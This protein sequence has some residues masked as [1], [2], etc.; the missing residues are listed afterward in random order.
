MTEGFTALNGMWLLERS[1]V[2]GPRSALQVSYFSR[3]ADM[4]LVAKVTFGS[5]AEGPPNHAH[6]GSIAAV[7]DEAMGVSAW[8]AGHR[9]L[10]AKIS[11]EFKKPIPLGTCATL[12]A[13][14]SR[15]EG[16]KVTTVGQLDGPD[17]TRYALGEGVY[18]MM[19]EGKLEEMAG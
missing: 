6:G 16:R 9:V 8:L 2:S 10:A 14:V 1:Y 3:D 13:W 11:I 17:G 12:T 7:L 5:G 18:V 4:A 19:R 15:V